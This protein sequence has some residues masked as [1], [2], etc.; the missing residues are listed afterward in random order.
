MWTIQSW[1]D[2][3]YR[4]AKASPHM[5][6]RAEH[7]LRTYAKVMPGETR[8]SIG[9]VLAEHN[10]KRLAATPD[11]TTYPE[12]RGLREF[13]AAGWRGTRDGAEMD[14][15]QAA[16]AAD[17][18]NYMH[19]EF[20]AK[21]TP[22]P[23]CCSVVY[24]HASDHGA[25]LGVNLDTDIHEP[26]GPPEWPLHNEHLVCGGVSSG[27]FLD[28]VSPEIFPAPVF[29]LMERYSRTAE[30][31]VELL[32]RYKLFW[33]PGNF[34]VADRKGR[35]AMIEKSACR[36]GVRWSHDGFGFVTAMTAEHPEMHAYLED[37]RQASLAPRGLTAPCAD[38]RYWALQDT[39]RAIMNRLLDAARKA[40]TLES[41]RALM[42][43]RG[44]DGMVCDNGD[45][46]SPGD[47]PLEFTI[48]TQIVCL[49]EGRALWW[50]RDN[51]TGAPSWEH[52]MPEV[53][54]T[55]V[56]LWP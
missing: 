31:A 23:A 12:L 4:A 29:T 3:G 5:R 8:E 21:L 47:P 20:Y 14:E 28:E 37:R 35:V 52:P 39:R 43:Y 34:L 27:V 53:T 26:Y 22:S 46:L 50:T 49:S 25:L 17:G 2:D 9:R 32:T 19:R 41:L 6:D 13:I 24:Y 42:Q 10:R 30:E 36:I 15:A 48:K 18:L 56:L 51:E 44:P 55:D 45:V 1:Y 33:G 54:F 38:T 16:A 40:P 7:L 11:L